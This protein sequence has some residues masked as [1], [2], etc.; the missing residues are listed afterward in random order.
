LQKI[1]RTQRLPYPFAIA[2]GLVN[3]NRF[4]VESLPTGILI[5]KKGVIRYIGTGSNHADEE[6]EKTIKKLL[7]E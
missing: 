5:D 1:K 3:H 4:S 2:K 6:M 7:S